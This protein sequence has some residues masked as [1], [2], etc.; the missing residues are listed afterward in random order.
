MECHKIF[1]AMQFPD[2]RACEPEITA[3]YRLYLRLFF[4]ES[5]TD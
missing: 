1:F 2:V 4:W 3:E 5:L